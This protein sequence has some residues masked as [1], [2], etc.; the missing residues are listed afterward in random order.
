MYVTSGSR[1]LTSVEDAIRLLEEHGDA[2][3]LLAGG[4]S[5][6]PMMKLRLATPAVLID[7][8]EIPNLDEIRALESSLDSS[9]RSGEGPER[10]AAQSLPWAE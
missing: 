10:P 6:I 2:A 4:H 3:K 5:V 8:A 1:L 7:I 9:P